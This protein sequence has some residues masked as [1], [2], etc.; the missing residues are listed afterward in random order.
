MAFD[1]NCL[2]FD[3]FYRESA[4]L[5]P[6]DEAHRSSAEHTEHVASIIGHELVSFLTNFFLAVNHTDYNQLHLHFC[7]SNRRING[8]EI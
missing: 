4:L 1:L 6:T 8:L 7:L 2:I 3:L 5:V